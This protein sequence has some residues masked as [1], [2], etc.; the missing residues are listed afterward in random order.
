MTD[1]T[2]EVPPEVHHYNHRGEVPWDIQNYWSQRYKIF[3]RYDEGVW[4]TDDAWFGVTP[5]PVANKIAE[6]MVE[7]APA[8]RS[9]LVDAFA[10]A[11]GNTIAFARTGRWKRIYAIEKDP[12]VLR[13]AKHNAK[14][15]GVQDKITW[16]EGSCFDILKNQLKDLAPYSIIFASPPWGGPGYRYDQV[17]NLCTMEPYSL[18]TL[19]KEYSAFSEHMVLYLPR[20]S[21]LRQLAKVVEDG[22]KVTV[23]HYCMEGASKALCIFYG[24]FNIQ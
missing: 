3:S 14:V 19:Y 18:A 12:A 2:E 11:G 22:Q 17:F 4:L 15:Y 1:D 20:T 5:E 10:G 8:G 9:I 23:M 13:C 16:F 7:S 21:D 24:G 6:Q